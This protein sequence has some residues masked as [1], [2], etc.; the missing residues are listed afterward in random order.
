MRFGVSVRHA[1]SAF[2]EGALQSSAVDFIEIAAED[3]IF[4]KDIL[5][6]R[7]LARLLAAKPVS[8]HSYSLSLADPQPWSDGRMGLYFEFLR[9]HPFLNVS[10]HYAVSSWRGRMLG[11]L[12]PPPAPTAELFA[13]ALE[14]LSRLK[15]AV[16]QLSILVENTAAPFV[17]EARPPSL[18]EGLIPLLQQSGAGLLLDLSNLVANEVNFGVQAE[19]ELERLTGVLIGEVHLAGGSWERGFLRDSHASP[20]AERSWEL[21]RRILPRLSSETLVLI[22]REQDHPHWSELEKEIHYARALAG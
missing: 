4:R 11:S 2:L 21:F 14:K 8:V 13:T 15:G 20:V 10:D 18:V 6:Q 5:N 1:P 19:E 17:R 16:P 9:C 7:K 22:E 3:F 12:T